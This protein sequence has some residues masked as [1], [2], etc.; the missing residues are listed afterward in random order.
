M[1]VFLILGAVIAILRCT[2]AHV[3]LKGVVSGS[4]EGKMTFTTLICEPDAI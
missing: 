2:K 3:L 4:F 1:V